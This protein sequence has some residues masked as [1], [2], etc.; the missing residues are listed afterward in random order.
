MTTAVAEAF[1][2]VNTRQQSI[3]RVE[4]DNSPFTMKDMKIARQLREVE[5]V[6]VS[7]THQ[8]YLFVQNNPGKTVKQM[9][10][11]EELK[12]FSAGHVQV[13]VRDL[14]EGG[15]LAR[16]D[17]G[18]KTRYNNPD[19]FYRVSQKEYIPRPSTRK[20]APND[21]KALKSL[22]KKKASAEPKVPPKLEF[23]K[24]MVALDP[25]HPE[26][27]TNVQA[28]G[29]STEVVVQAV[30]PAKNGPVKPMTT[31]CFEVGNQTLLAT[32]KDAY[33]LYLELH[34]IFGPKE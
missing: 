5:I 20:V 19:Y 22:E 31:M 1:G 27:N 29:I 10:E 18:N 23:V 16:T 2:R 28:L 8:V 9:S 4:S 3:K 6:P 11:A 25:T 26:F 34:S 24:G 32:P 14:Y 17:S 15:Y 30:E 33:Q 12:D 13:A 21:R 7:K